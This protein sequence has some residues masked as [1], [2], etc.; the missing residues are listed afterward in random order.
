MISPLI[1][2]S[3]RYIP[4]CSDYSIQAFKNYGFFKGIKLML[5]RITKCHPFGGSGLDPI[6]NLDKIDIK[7]VPVS[8]IRKKRM[9]Q[10]YQDLPTSF[11]KYNEDEKKSTIHIGLFVN[12]KLISGLTLIKNKINKNHTSSFQIRGM[13]TDSNFS[14]KGYGSKLIDYVKRNF[15][16]KKTTLWCNSRKEAIGFYKNNG[17]EELG[18]FFLVRHIGIHKKLIIMSK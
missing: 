16:K 7:R 6:E 17:F 14:G 13:F 12:K 3:C 5:I 2:S 9:E 1:T 15:L 8:I 4:T 10:L 18:D 11:S